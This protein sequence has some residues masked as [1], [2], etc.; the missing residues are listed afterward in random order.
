MTE[1]GCGCGAVR[2]ALAGAPLRVGVCHCTT[3]RKETGAPFMAFAVWPGA[4]VT[5]RG[6]T[7][8]WAAATEQRHFCALCGSRLFATRA[9]DDEVEVRLG[10]LDEA[11]SGLVPTYELWVAR[12]EAWLAAVPGAAQQASNG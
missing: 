4:A 5:V 6:E 12:R 1:G 10:A 11:P 7:R 2:F 3:C 9:A 8:V